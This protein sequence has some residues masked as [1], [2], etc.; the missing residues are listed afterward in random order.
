MKAVLG[1]Q[2]QGQPLGH[3]R[4]PFPAVPGSGCVD[5]QVPEGCPGLWTV[6][7]GLPEQDSHLPKAL[8]SF[9]EEAPL[10]VLFVHSGLKGRASD[11]P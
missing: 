4:S 1:R 10:L 11:P 7:L 2:V 5:N 3:S 9:W 6:G 8:R